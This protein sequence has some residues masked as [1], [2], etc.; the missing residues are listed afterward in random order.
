MKLKK[1]IYFIFFYNFTFSSEQ[2]FYRFIFSNN[3]EDKSNDLNGILYKKLGEFNYKKKDN[4]ENINNIYYDK[5]FKLEIERENF[6]KKIIF[7]ILNLNKK[8]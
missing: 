6:F 8:K 4:N 5:N 1:V 7:F 2:Y 3:E